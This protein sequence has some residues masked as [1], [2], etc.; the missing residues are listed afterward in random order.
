[1]PDWVTNWSRF[2]ASASSVLRRHWRR[3]LLWRERI[4]PSEE[5]LHLLMAG[6]IG[7]L[8]GVVNLVYFGFSQI[9]E[10]LMLGGMGDVVG[11]A[12][13]LSPWYK[14]AGP[15]VGGLV[16]G[17]ILFYGLRL[18]GNP[19]LT[20]LLEVVVA[21]NGRLP[22]RHALV[23]ALSSLVS[24]SS[25]ASIGREGPI[26]HLSATLASKSGQWIKWPPYR[27]R[28]LVAC[29]AAAGMAAAYNAPVAGAL[30]AA[31]IVLGNFSMTLFAPLI[32]SSVVAAVFSRSFF[33]IEPWYHVRDF[34]V[35]G[36][37]QLPLFVVLGVLAGATGAVFMRM[38]HHGEHLWSR[39][40]AP[41][42]IRLGLA[43]LLVGLIGLKYP[44]VWGNGYHAINRILG[45]NLEV[46]F[47]LGLLVAKLVAT[48]TTVGAGAVGGVMTPTLFVGAALGSLF[49]ETLH[50]AGW[51]ARLDPAPFALVGMAAVLAATTHS[52]LLAMVLVFELSSNYSLMP[53]LMLACAVATLVA[54]RLHPESV[55]T[56]PLRRKGLEWERENQRIGAALEKSVGDVM[57]EPVPPLPEAATFQEIAQRFL[58]STNNFLPV[59]G[60]DHKL[61][62]VVALQDLKEHLNRGEELSVVIA[63]DVMRPP[64]PCLTPNQP[65][66]DALPILL[67]SE[68]RNV[69]VLNDRRHGRL[70]GAVNRS[71]VLSM[72][73]EAF[74]TKTV[75]R[76]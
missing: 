1:M 40:R 33:G 18:I 8:A 43:G 30:F 64:P 15:T 2:R 57:R 76:I 75:G 23:S 5:A 37:G 26:V 38:L 7:V 66:T 13:E 17:L 20:N 68:L 73:S 29:G 4:R 16:A 32:V 14:L 27:L 65:L 51:G 69:P 58:S 54:R 10:M 35:T 19:G 41:L 25:G 53:P 52:P 31:L 70:V 47:I 34:Q 60:A 3:A 39:V 21:G 63:A 45:E 67:A 22:A 49:H 62:G 6:V 48:T 50:L 61:L 71:E 28:L 56:E 24:I 55:Y 72:I 59:V 12:R 36:L 74:S 46:G 9:L 11:I 44:E 42:Y